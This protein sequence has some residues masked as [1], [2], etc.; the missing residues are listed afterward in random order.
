MTRCLVTSQLCIQ[1]QNRSQTMSM[2]LRRT[3]TIVQCQ[4]TYLPH[5]TFLVTYRNQVTRH[6]SLLL[7]QWCS[8]LFVS[9]Y[10]NNR[11]WSTSL[12]HNLRVQERFQSTFLI[13][14]LFY[15]F[16]RETF[17]LYKYMCLVCLRSM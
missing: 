14:F 7:S 11:W 1:I 5:C 17:L 13:M 16:G 12:S 8:R 10:R 6:P 3:R 9:W 2:N 4:Q 15:C